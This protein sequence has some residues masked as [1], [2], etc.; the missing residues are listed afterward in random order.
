MDLTVDEVR[1]LFSGFER[2]IST[3]PR[4][5]AAIALDVLDAVMTG[6]EARG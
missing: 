5:Q 2:E 3:W 4:E 1:A 6:K